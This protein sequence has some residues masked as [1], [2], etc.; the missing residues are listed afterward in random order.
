MSE[1]HAEMGAVCLKRRD[2]AQAE[3]SLLR[4][5]ELRPENYTANLNLMILYQ[6]IKDPRAAPQAER[7]RALREKLDQSKMEMLRSIQV[8]P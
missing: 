7:F 3:K 4:A 8:Q 2:Y 1:A 5:I 6:R